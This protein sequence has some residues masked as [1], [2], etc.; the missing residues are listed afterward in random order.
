[1]SSCPWPFPQLTYRIPHGVHEQV[2]PG[3]RVVV[4]LGKT[5]RYTAIVRAVHENPPEYQAKYVEAVLDHKPIVTEGQLRLW[6]WM[7]DYYVC[8]TGEVM[9][10]ALPGSFRLASETKVVLDSRWD[11][12]DTGLNDKEFLIVEGLQIQGALSIG[13]ITDLLDQRLSSN[14]SSRWWKK[15]W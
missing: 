7:A 11:G 10:A 8:T 4:Q 13:D 12:D 15:A 1:M 14:T 3:M 5:K 9:S 2:L 6:E